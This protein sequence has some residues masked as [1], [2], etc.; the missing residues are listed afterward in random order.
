VSEKP[1]RMIGLTRKSKGEDEGTHTDQK[2]LIEEYIARD[3]SLALLR[4]EKEHKV[5]GA[6]QWREREIGRAI[7]DVSDGKADGIIV[8]WTDRITRER[9][10]A[11]AEIWQAM[12]DAGVVFISCNGADSRREDAEFSFGI[13][14]LLARRQWKTFQKRSNMGRERSVMEHGV[15]AGPTASLGYDFT[16]RADGSKNIKGAPKHG[17]LKPNK[18]RA[19]IP[20]AF[21]AFL[22]DKPWSV[23]VSIL[24]VNSQGAARHILEDRVYLGE[25]KSGDYVKK[26]A[27]E[28]LVT[29][30]Q[31]NDVQRKLRE[32]RRSVSYVLKGEKRQGALLGGGILRCAGCGGSLT[33][34]GTMAKPGYRCQYR[35][36]D[37][38]ERHPQGKPGIQAAMIEP[39]VM[40]IALG[41]HRALHPS[42]AALSEADAAILPV[43]KE[44]LA[45]AE[46][47]L[48]EVEEMRAEWDAVTYGNARADAVKAVERARQSVEEAEAHQGWL[49]T[50]PE[51]VAQKLGLRME[52]TVET[53][54]LA[55]LPDHSIPPEGA[56]FDAE[57]ERI[58]GW[59]ADPETVRSFVRDMVR[60]F[61]KPVGRG[62]RRVPVPAEERIKVQYLA[63]G[64]GTDP[65]ETVEPP[66][67]AVSA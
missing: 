34:D 52:T 5:S 7:E 26:N 14:A 37:K 55:L 10:L 31:F 65:F 18:D 42:Y 57:T 36:A 30:E 51:R 59:D 64:K 48:A 40:E 2:R 49:G 63:A 41:W 44:E 46:A 23:I 47:T 27:H 62:F 50:T 66:V 60:V 17:P 67:V 58:V 29:E 53:K 43:L 33:F 28:P 4:V 24:G 32:N 16:D 38:A 15:H 39:V 11:A 56:T 54:P 13:E 45:K 22:E 19:R 12:E 3:P 8:A 20:K 1:L 35:G 6:R 25:A 21:D 61:V 9:L